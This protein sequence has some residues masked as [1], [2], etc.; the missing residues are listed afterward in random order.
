MSKSREESTGDF[1]ERWLCETCGQKNDKQLLTHRKFGSVLTYCHGRMVQLEVAPPPT[2]GAVEITDE[3]VE[4]AAL[5]L[6][7][8]P[9]SWAEA[10]AHGDTDA[11][12]PALLARTMLRAALEGTDD[13]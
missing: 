8:A 9:A 11:D 7:R 10:V 4:R 5:A 3:M 6:C 1:P 13:Q 12:Y 2:P